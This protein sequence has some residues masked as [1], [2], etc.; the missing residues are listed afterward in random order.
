MLTT[1][2]VILL[3][4]AEHVVHQ[5]FSSEN[6]CLLWLETTLMR[7]EQM[8]WNSKVMVHNTMNK[9]MQSLQMASFTDSHSFQH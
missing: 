4:G 2:F 1:N 6:S 7:V 8:D 9:K 3:F 5:S